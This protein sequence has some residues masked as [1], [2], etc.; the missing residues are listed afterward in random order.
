MAWVEP[1]MMHTAPRV[2]VEL[3]P[4]AHT[5]K[6]V[7]LSPTTVPTSA[8]ALPTAAGVGKVLNVGEMDQSTLTPLPVARNLPEMQVILPVPEF[9]P[10]EPT[11][12]S[13]NPSLF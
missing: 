3:N 2:K 7:A 10:G 1:S 13:L 4:G 5:A 8:M 12:S 11:S 6:S 9:A